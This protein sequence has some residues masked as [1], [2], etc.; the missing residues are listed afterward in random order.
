MLSVLMMWLVTVTR[1]IRE[2]NSRVYPSRWHY[3]E[4]S[5]H[6][7]FFHCVRQVLY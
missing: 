7:A 5:S 3:R 6:P 2:D 4:S 1:R